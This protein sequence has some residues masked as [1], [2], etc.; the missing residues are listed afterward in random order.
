M[1]LLLKF[2]NDSIFDI[3]KNL[4]TFQKNDELLDEEL[5]EYDLCILEVE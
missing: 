5:I 1:Y 4:F 3:G 2:E